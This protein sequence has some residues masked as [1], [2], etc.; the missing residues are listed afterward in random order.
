[1][2]VFDCCL[3]Y[4]E[5]DL[6]ELRLHT[7][8]WADVHVVV[9]ATRTFSNLPKPIRLDPFAPRFAPFKD[10]L[11]HI[12][13]ADLNWPSASGTALEKGARMALNGEQWEKA[14]D[15][16]ADAEPG[17]MIVL[18]DLD[19]ILRAEAIEDAKRILP[20]RRCVKFSVTR[21]WYYLNGL[22][23]GG[24]AGSVAGLAEDALAPGASLWKFRQTRRADKEVATISDAGWHFAYQGGL[25]AVY[26]KLQSAAHPEWDRFLHDKNA[27]GEW[28]EAG[29]R[30]SPNHPQ[31]GTVTPVPIDDTFPPYL[32][33]N[34]KR[35]KHMIADVP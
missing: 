35:F 24:W 31:P 29:R 8:S 5:L 3:F 2:K 7:H 32:V 6:L 14:R 23:I 4:N 21:Y 19:E 20:E 9:E 22:G 18:T 28:I 11:R 26:L 33:A 30:F 15:G 34:Q 16:L 25:D 12:V 17:D 1:M 10:A 27:L 13:A